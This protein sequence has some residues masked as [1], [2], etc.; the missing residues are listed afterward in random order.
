M[1]PVAKRFMKWG[2][3]RAWAILFSD[4]IIMLS[5]AFMIFLLAAQANNVASNWPKI[6][7]KL[8][9]KIEQARQF[10]QE[11]VNSIGS[12]SSSSENQQQSSPSDNQQQGNSEEQNNSNGQ[13]SGNEKQGGKSQPFG[14]EQITGFL[15]GIVMNV[16][17]FISN[18]LLILV[19]VF[20][21]MFYQKKFEDALIGLVPKNKQEQ[22]KTI[23]K[24][25]AKIAQKYLF[26]RFILIGGLAVLYMIS[27]SLLGLEYAVFI[28][29]LG[30]LFTLIPY[31]GNIIALGLALGMSFI[32]G[33]ETGQMIGI[34]I[35]FGI[36]QFIE[37]YIM[38][39]YIVGDKVDLNPVIIIVGVILGGLVWGVMGMLLVI[40]VMG[41]IKVV[42]DSIDTLRPF[43]YVLDER[44]ISSGGGTIEKVKEWV[45]KK[46]KK[47]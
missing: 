9:P 45:L 46:L 17:S 27:F 22:A 26:G 40:P 11:K 6:Q 25:S 44:G 10:Y 43:G 33:G 38:E 13:E 24:D 34:I 16:F 14:S 35:A 1:Y 5:I 36:I 8:Q 4:L 19:Y 37:S 32:S 30:A 18:M 29:L 41:I 23:I 31:V 15:T 3:G 42:F 7:E 21:F 28:A 39:P 20:F 12:P 2:I 47:K